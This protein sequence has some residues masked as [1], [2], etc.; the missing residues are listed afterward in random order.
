MCSREEKEFKLR[1]ILIVK[2]AALLERDEWK[3]K[4]KKDHNYS[5][6]FTHY[7]FFAYDSK[8]IF[9]WGLNTFNLNQIM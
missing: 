9:R 2:S 1:V 8:S 4:K 7:V 6:Y 3:A 5:D